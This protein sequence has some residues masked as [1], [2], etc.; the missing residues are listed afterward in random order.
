MNQIISRVWPC[1]C[2]VQRLNHMHTHTYLFIYIYGYMYSVQCEA[3][4]ENCRT[5]HSTTNL[6]RIYQALVI[7]M[8]D[9]FLVEYELLEYEYFY[10]IMIVHRTENVNKNKTQKEWRKTCDKQQTFE[11]A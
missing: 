8:A 7:S 3:N 9:S 2:R 6:M 10:M 1:C 4:H 5:K 11:A